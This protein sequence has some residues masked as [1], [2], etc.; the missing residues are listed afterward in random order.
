MVAQLLA[1]S[2]SL[3]LQFP[4]QIRMMTEE[5][6]KEYHLKRLLEL[7]SKSQGKIPQLEEP[8]EEQRE[9][10]ERRMKAPAWTCEIWDL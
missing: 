1:H 2:Q 10:L 7:S 8:N 3:Q 4:I 9:W 5:E 6:T